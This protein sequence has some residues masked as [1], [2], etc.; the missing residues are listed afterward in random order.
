LAVLYLSFGISPWWIR[1]FASLRAIDIVQISINVSL[2]DQF[3]RSHAVTSIRRS[4]AL[5]FASYL[6]L[7]ICFGL[8][9]LTLMDRLRGA[10]RW[11][12]AFYFS[13]VTQLTIGYGDI[14]PVGITR[15]LVV[16]QAIAGLA[17]VAVVLGRVVGT[18]KNFDEIFE[19]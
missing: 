2:F 5:T 6:E 19:P 12:D 3:R 11:Y 15:L 4:V 17:L 1:A 13:V 9:Y 14:Q 16:V 7:M 8:V 10:E 18:M